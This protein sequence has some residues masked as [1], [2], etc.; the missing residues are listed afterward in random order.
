M[1]VMR[2][3]FL[4]LLANNDDGKTSV[5]RAGFAGNRPK[6]AQFQV[7]AAAGCIVGS[8]R[9]CSDIRTLVRMDRG[10]SQRG[11]SH[12]DIPSLF[13]A[14]AVAPGRPLEL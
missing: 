8:A 11:Q 1:S 9:R 12:S 5:R 6:V 10:E 2:R 14:K 7:A 13:L 3:I 4:L